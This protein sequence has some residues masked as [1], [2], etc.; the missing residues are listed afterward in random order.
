MWG[1][2]FAKKLDFLSK[3]GIILQTQYKIHINS[4]LSW[5][6]E[7]KISGAYSL[8]LCEKMFSI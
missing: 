5:Q 2:F 1:V 8:S 4:K 3:T 7:K 6:E